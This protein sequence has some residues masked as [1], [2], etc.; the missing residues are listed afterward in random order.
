MKIGHWAWGDEGDEEDKQIDESTPLFQLLP[1]FVESN[2][3]LT[4][5]T[6]CGYHC[7]YLFDMAIAAITSNSDLLIFILN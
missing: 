7:R 1:F 6:D 5:G 3:S 2:Q 4:V